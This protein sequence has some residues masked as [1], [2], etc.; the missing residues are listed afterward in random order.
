M[1]N[2][3]IS[4]EEG[5][6]YVR[7]DALHFIERALSFAAADGLVT[8]DEQRHILQLVTLFQIPAPM[9]HQI[10]ARIAYLRELSDIREGRLPTIHPSVRLESDEICHLEMPA[11]YWKTTA[12]NV[13]KVPGRLVATNKKLHFLSGSGGTEILWKSVLRVEAQ[14]GGFYLELSKK[15]GNGMYEVPDPGRAEATLD[16]LTRIAKR[17]V[18]V[19]KGGGNARRIPHEVRIAVWQRDQGKCVQCSAA[20]Y[21]EFDHIIPV[22]KGGANT[23]GNVQLLCRRC[24]LQKSDRI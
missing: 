3:R 9:A 17:E 7:G 15:G 6:A 23:V 18:L 24:N 22:A 11:T 10:Q 16:T 19:T 21:L 2:A 4:L 14:P 13:H 12:K 20:E 8:S 1:A 5:L